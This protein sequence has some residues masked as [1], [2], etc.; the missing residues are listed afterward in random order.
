[1]KI[2]YIITFVLAGLVFGVLLFLFIQYLICRI[3][4]KRTLYK[5][6]HCNFCERTYIDKDFEYC[7]ICGERLTLHYEDPLFRSQY[8]GRVIHYLKIRE[9]YYQAINDRRKRFE[10]RNNDRDFH[11]GDLIVFTRLFSN[12][13]QALD[14][15]KDPVIFYQIDYV[16]KNV[17]Q[18]GLD[19]DYCILTIS[20]AFISHK[21]KSEGFLEV[22]SNE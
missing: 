21:Y 16:L 8:R 12:K 22:M 19:K 6:K 7:P 2:I 20:K 1:M 9:E 13:E 5:E 3:Q 17:P 10:L 14:K 18:Y 15:R 11:I 4:G